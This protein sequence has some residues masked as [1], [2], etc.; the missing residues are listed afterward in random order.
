[1]LLASCGGNASGAKKTETRVAVAEP[2]N[3][4]Y[5]VRNTYPHLT[6]S[7]TQGLQFIDGILWEGTG[8]YG[9]SV[10]Q[11][12]DLATGKAEVVARL[13][14]SEFGEGI[15]VL[16]GKVYQL[17]WQS[18]KA[19]VYDAATG[20]ILRTHTYPGEGWG[21]TTDGKQLYLSDGSENIYTIDPETFKRGKRTTVTQKGEPVRF[22]NELEW[23]DG[24][25]WAN[26]Y[27]TEQIK[28][29]D[30]ATGVVEGVI[31][32]AGILPEADVRPET[33]VLNGIAYD[34]AT[35]RIFVTGKNW[36]KLFEIGIT[37]K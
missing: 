8:E 11:K 31:D 29:I 20:K 35:G 32:L 33:D 21:L 5:T 16:D 18:N 6:S 37:E 17:T 13:P 12:V 7:Y 27:G 23:I 3:Y 28:I 25:I 24:K 30:P 14:R 22:L 15:T 36:D 10:L 1:M 19:Y 26:V 2:K 9:H 34:A 4:T